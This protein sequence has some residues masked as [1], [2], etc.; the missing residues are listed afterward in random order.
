MTIHVTPE[1]ECSYVSFETNVPAD[2]YKEI[3]GKVLNT[4]Q[5][6][7]FMITCFT[8]EVSNFCQ[9]YP[10]SFNYMKYQP[11]YFFFQ[12]SSP[13]ETTREMR[14]LTQL[15]EYERQDL[16]TCHFKNYDLVYAFFCRF[17]SWGFQ[18]RQR[19]NAAVV[20]VPPTS[21]SNSP[22]PRIP[23]V[24]LPPSPIKCLPCLK[25]SQSVF[26]LHNYQNLQPY[27]HHSHRFSKNIL[28]FVDLQEHELFY[29][30]VRMENILKNMLISLLKYRTNLQN[31]KYVIYYPIFSKL[32]VKL[33]QKITDVI[34]TVVDI[35]ELQYKYSFKKQFER[36]IRDCI[37][38]ISYE[39]N[40]LLM[41][42]SMLFVLCS[43][44]YIRT[45]FE[46]LLVLFLWWRNKISWELL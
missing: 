21:F 24:S 31:S 19:E 44:V 4:F 5:P 1:P 22:I 40:F 28:K 34:N 23:S 3:I 7:K 26:L 25:N 41:L 39:E 46:S 27:F 38:S 29:F 15:G 30:T 37:N 36:T 32:I 10:I 33:N 11:F 2:S 45:E 43:V 8:S 42:F 9:I 6:G 17:P 13:K 12:T 18:E 20:T 35:L 14:Q 16:Q